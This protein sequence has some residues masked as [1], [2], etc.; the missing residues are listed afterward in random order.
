MAGWV[1]HGT[2][3]W[4]ELRVHGVS[5]TPPEAMLEHPTVRRVSGDAASG[6]YRRVWQARSI[7]A[8][9]RTSVLE[10]YSWG[11][12]T[13][14]S[15][16]RALWLLLIPFLLANVAFYARPADRPGFRQRLGEAV[17][18]L[19][20]LTIT[21]TLVLATVNVSMDFAGWQCVRPGGAGSCSSAWAGFLS[22]PWLDTPGRRIALTALVP[23]AVVALLWWLANKTWCANEV[24][25]VEAVDADNGQ[26]SPLENRRMWNSARPVRRLRAV[27][28]TAALALV[29][30]L[31]LAPFTRDRPTLLSGSLMGVL[32]ATGL[33][34]LVLVCLPSMSDRPDTGTEDD[35]GASTRFIAS[36]PWLTLGLVAVSLA[37]M[38]FAKP[39]PTG[40]PGAPRT[41]LPWLSA[42]VHI[43]ITV[44]IVLLII[45]V[46][47]LTAVRR[48]NKGAAWFGY[49]TA[50]LM[51]FGSALSGAYAAAMVLAVAHLLGK[52]MP[53]DRGIDPLV[54]PMPYFWA[55]A[56][57][58]VVAAAAVIVGLYGYWSLRRLARGAMLTKVNITYPGNTD[59][60]RA[61]AI[62]KQWALATADKTLRQ[63]AG[64]FVA[65]TVV[66]IVAACIGYAAE[67]TAV[68]DTPVLAGMANVGDWLIGLFAAGLLYLGRQT[69]RNANTR[70][71][72][73]IIW[74]LG[75]FWPRAAH[76]LA[77]PCYAER[78]VPELVNRI[79]HLR[80][81][82]TANVLLS[83]HSQGTVLGAAVIMQ[84]TYEQSSSVALLTYGAPLDRLY[85]PFFP[86][87]FGP[88]QLR[89]TG[90]FLVHGT[91]LPVARWPWRNLYRPSDPIGGPVLGADCVDRPLVDPVFGRAAGDISYPPTLG[92]S[93]YTDAPE[94][95]AAVEEVKELRLSQVPYG[96]LATP[97]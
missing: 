70:R 53:R 8:D 24:T 46:V 57:A 21:A 89:R 5:G 71:L 59:P 20:A 43:G 42:A 48:H 36:L 38:W 41:S 11:G 58:L 9:D 25:P 35:G 10:A 14:G 74:D 22:W 56:L 97:P 51:L 26:H 88:A 66:L 17:Q 80:R 55:A 13:A 95:A 68:T 33:L 27:H 4:T 73:G 96:L 54:T 84:L 32:L 94:W 86:A 52:P 87:Y 50:I 69:F 61:R 49:A 75:T 77:P 12:L 65:L 44:Q 81:D 39:V 93:G 2:A 18:R 83:C 30:I 16:L 7:A 90:S 1:E 78:A 23:I 34:S 62:A 29:G 15:K 60:V 67:Q 92:H 37:W 6:F 79:D 45:M 82:G 19:F 31:A 63:V 47:L 40:S 85:A 64:R 91:D 28:V 72:V 76:P 3:D